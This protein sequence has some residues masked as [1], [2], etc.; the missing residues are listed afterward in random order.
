M[1]H[2]V[3]DLL[4]LAFWIWHAAVVLNP[5]TQSRKQ[6]PA[7]ALAAYAATES[8][9]WDPQVYSTPDRHFAL[10]LTGTLPAGIVSYAVRPEAGWQTHR[11]LWDPIWLLVH[12]SVAI[13]FWFLLG[14]WLDTG[15]SKLVPAMRAYVLLRVVLAVMAMVLP[16]HT[17]WIPQFLFWLTLAG[18]GLLRVIH[19]VFGAG[20]RT[21][22]A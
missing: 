19:G 17:W 14:M 3:V 22:R 8:I 18:Y 21:A 20:R 16:T 6:L 10:M 15:R 9:G 5:L 1:T 7:N 12:E 13:P 2:A 11:R 4:L